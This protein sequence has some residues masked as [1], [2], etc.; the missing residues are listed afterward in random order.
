MA[1]AQD[2]KVRDDAS[3]QDEQPYEAPKVESLKLT[4]EAAEALT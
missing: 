1:K 3:R 2:D 4:D